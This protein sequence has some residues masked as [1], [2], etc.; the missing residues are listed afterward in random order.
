[1][2]ARLYELVPVAREIISVANDVLGYDLGALLLE[3]PIDRLSD[4]RY[5]QP[6]IYTCSA[7]YLAK[8]RADGLDCD[9]VAGHSLGE[10]NALLAAGVF[11]FADGLRLVAKRGELM[12][13][14]NGR[15]TMAAV[16]GL[17]ERQ[18]GECMSDIPDIVMAN[19][20]SR[21]QIVVSGTNVAVAEV[22]RRVEG[23]DGVRFRP[24]RVSAAFHSPQM[25]EAAKKMEEVI[26]SVDFSR[27]KCEVV[28]NISGA[29]TCDIKEIRRCL[30]AQIT[31]QVR[32]MDTVLAMKSAGVKTLYEIGHGD[33]LKKLNKTIAFRPKC[34][35][36]DV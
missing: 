10:Y 16:L 21:N 22:G 25:S 12:A 17:T 27:P 5:A 20:N 2:G 3:G 8:V 29:P 13:Q 33:V 35:G 9:Y 19:L 23:I 6:A 4:T 15:G 28:P 7:M 31:G 32:W 30:V 24:L 18:L 14:M 11:D 1:M 36:V 34:L 26:E